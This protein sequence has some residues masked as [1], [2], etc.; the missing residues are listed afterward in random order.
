MPAILL[1]LVFWLPCGTLLLYGH[2]V[3]AVLCGLATFA[4]ALRALYM[5]CGR[6][7]EDRNNEEAE[8]P[9]DGGADGQ[10]PLRMA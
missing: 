8:H 5:A 10:P 9:D 3:S 7:E 4:V 2:P 1:A 6:C